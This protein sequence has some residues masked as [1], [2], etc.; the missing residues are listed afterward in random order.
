MEKNKE[1]SYYFF[2]FAQESWSKS[3]NVLL[4]QNQDKLK[5]LTENSTSKSINS[6]DYWKIEKYCIEFIESKINVKFKI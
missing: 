2:K 1:Q 3:S 5:I 4:N 6:Q